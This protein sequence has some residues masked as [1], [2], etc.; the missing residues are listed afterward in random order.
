MLSS[1][2]S[3]RAIPAFMPKST[4]LNL[5]ACRLNSGRIGSD[6]SSGV[7]LSFSS[8]MPDHTSRTG[9]FEKAKTL[10]GNQGERLTHPPYRPD[11]ALSD[12]HLC[13]SLQHSNV[14]LVK[15]HLHGF[16]LLLDVLVCNRKYYRTYTNNEFMTET[17][18]YTLDT[19]QN[20]LDA[21][22]IELNTRVLGHKLA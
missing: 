4:L 9:L 8:I 1:G 12:G 16:F 6:N 10:A 13:R 19:F 20:E 7:A 18:L 3:S 17:L 11:R 21:F 2:N 5:T 22:Q 15:M 14:D